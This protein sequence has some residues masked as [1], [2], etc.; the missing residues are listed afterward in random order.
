MPN[1]NI[2]LPEAHPVTDATARRITRPWLA[3]LQV[4]TDTLITAITG[5]PASSTDNAIVRWD[6]TTGTAVKDS[7]ITI[8]DG[9]SGELS[10][11]NTGDQLTF[12]LVAVAGQSDVV[13]ETTGD[14]LTLVEGDNITITTSASGRAITITA[15]GSG[16]GTVT[17]TGTPGAGQLTQFSGAS[18]ITNGDLT[19]DVTTS[20]TLATTIADGVVTFAKLQ[21]IDTQTLLGR[22]SSGTGPPEQVTI[23]QALDWLTT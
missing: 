20:G 19:G 16:F 4:V 10:G 12:R 13:A 8:P 14:T 11:T 7:G 17:I 22:N 9:A 18:S 15:S 2:W 6:G 23:S 1:S 5:G 21:D 3:A